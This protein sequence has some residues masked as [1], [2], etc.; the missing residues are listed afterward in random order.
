MQPI[1]VN[2]KSCARVIEFCRIGAAKD[3]L[4]CRLQQEFAKD[5]ALQDGA[6]IER[7][8]WRIWRHNGTLNVLRRKLEPQAV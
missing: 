7:L 5:K 3:R 2:D 8:T 1:S 4:L 6:L